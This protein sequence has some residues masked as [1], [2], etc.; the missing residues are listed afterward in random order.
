MICRTRLYE[1]HFPLY[2]ILRGGATRK[3]RLLHQEFETCIVC[4][5]GKEE[6]S[7]YGFFTWSHH[8]EWTPAGYKICRY[9][10]DKGEC[11]TGGEPVLDDP[12]TL[13]DLSGRW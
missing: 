12:L 5:A 4:L 7:T 6:G 1:F 9:M 10:G 3:L 2:G 11:S 8:I 13:G